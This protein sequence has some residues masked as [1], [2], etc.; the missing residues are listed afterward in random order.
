MPCL[1]KYSVAVP[2]DI[3]SQDNDLSSGRN[4][5]WRDIFWDI[6]LYNKVV[7]PEEENTDSTLAR[8]IKLYDWSSYQSRLIFP[9]LSGW[10][11]STCEKPRGGIKNWMQ[12]TG[13]PSPAFLNNINSNCKCMSPFPPWTTQKPNC[14]M[15]C[16][17]YIVVI[18]KAGDTSMI[19][20]PF[21]L[22]NINFFTVW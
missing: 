9:S 5:E 21:H 18:S 10:G 6:R 12:L 13:Q 2:E 16:L 1:T 22:S 7:N 4:A 8:N 20:K 19:Q 14:C 15:P 3:P 11:Q 17:L